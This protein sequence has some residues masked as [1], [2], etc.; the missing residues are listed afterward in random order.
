MSIFLRIASS[1]FPVSHNMARNFAYI[2][3][4]I[5]EASENNAEVI[6]FPETALPGYLG[7]PNG[8]PQEFDCKNYKEKIKKVNQLDTPF[9]VIRANNSKKRPNGRRY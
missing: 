8:N 6:H 5:I 4:Q 2:Q 7:F 9:H 1:Q 3:K